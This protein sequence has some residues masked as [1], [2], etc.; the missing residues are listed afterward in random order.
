MNRRAYNAACTHTRR[1]GAGMAKGGGGCL[2]LSTS[3]QTNYIPN[4]V[5]VLGTSTF[6]RC[7]ERGKLRT[8]ELYICLSVCM[9]TC[10][11]FGWGGYTISV[12]ALMVMF[13]Y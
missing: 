5:V 4:D 2:V 13:G 10:T 1:L 11:Y 9:R 7:R 12:I 3:G 8:G 6:H